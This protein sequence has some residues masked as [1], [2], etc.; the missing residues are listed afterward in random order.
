MQVARAGLDP[1]TAGL[2]VGYAYHSVTLPPFAS[3]S[4]SYDV[5][6]PDSTSRGVFV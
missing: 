3:I 4:F 6:S 5:K 2:Q 1:G